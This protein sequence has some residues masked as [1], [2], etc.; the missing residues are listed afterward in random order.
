M[1][2]KDGVLLRVSETD[3][4]DGVFHFPAGIT[5]IGTGAFSHCKNLSQITI[6]A[7]V[8]SIGSSAFLLCSNL[9]KV[10]LSNGLNSIGDRAFAMCGN[11]IQIDIPNSVTSI[12]FEAFHTCQNLSQITIPDSITSIDRG[13]F[14][15]CR[16]A[17][18]ITIPSSI[19][20]IG[21]GAFYDCRSATQITI[22][23]SVTSIGKVAFFNC[24]SAT[25]IT[26][27]DSVTSIG[28]HAFASCRSPI[29][30]NIIANSTEEFTRV[31]SLLPD[32]LQ[33]AT[34]DWVQIRI[35]AL[36]ALL[37]NTKLKDEDEREWLNQVNTVIEQLHPL[38]HNQTPSTERQ[39]A[40]NSLMV[41]LYLLQN[42]LPAAL[43]Y[44]EQ[45]SNV[46][47]DTAARLMLVLFEEALKKTNEERIQEYKKLITLF[48]NYHEEPDVQK[49]LNQVALTL[50]AGPSVT[51]NSKL[52][53]YQV[54]RLLPFSCVQDV[55]KEIIGTVK[56]AP[57]KKQLELIYDN[58]HRLTAKEMHLLLSSSWLKKPFTEKYGSIN[59]VTFEALIDQK[60][61]A[62]VTTYTQHD[63]QELNNILKILVDLID[64]KRATP[65]NTSALATQ[66]LFKP[67]TP[68]DAAS[69][70]NK[71]TI[72]S[73][74]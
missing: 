20:S 54:D 40:F 27:H 12:G 15:N 6:P 13:T 14:H 11:L 44:F 32:T 46:A 33:S 28:V 57:V 22:P 7:S 2:I 23:N 10:T 21:D 45:R 1:D 9:I 17:T 63:D 29:Q 58:L 24:R 4:K 61:I 71:D 38:M 53:Q 69:S 36:K 66:G 74:P 70:S 41:Q 56:D 73:S 48:Q 55:I 3:I 47:P 62:E 31:R 19:T 30:I 42:D 65:N 43:E 26:I 35:D 34:V 68:L 16:S 59:I 5:S 8:S 67:E 72:K 18:Q 25:Q 49:L 60:S 37:A 51:I 50:L 39:T 64:T 52:T